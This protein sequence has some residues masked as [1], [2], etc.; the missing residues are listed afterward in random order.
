MLHFYKSCHMKS[1]IGYGILGRLLYSFMN[2]YFSNG[3]KF[4]CSLDIY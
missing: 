2:V 3:G 1:A 4:F